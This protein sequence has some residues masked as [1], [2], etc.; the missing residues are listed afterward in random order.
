MNWEALICT[1]FLMDCVQLFALQCV[2]SRL[3]FTRL[4]SA[5]LLMLVCTLAATLFRPKAWMLAVATAAVYP[6]SVIILLGRQPLRRLA[7]ASACLFC[8]SAASA[9]FSSIGSGTLT[10]L[11]FPGVVLM[12]YLLR[13][14]WN[15]RCCWNIELFL[16]LDGL[17]ESFPAL[18]DTGNRLREGAS[19]LPVLIVESGAVPRVARHAAHMPPDRFKTLPYGVLGGG[20]RLR[21]FLPDRLEFEARGCPRRSAPECWVALYT[22]RIPGSTRALAPPE[23]LEF[24]RRSR[25]TIKRNPDMP[26]RFMY[27]IFKH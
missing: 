24:T 22:G 7:E 17:R 1:D 15:T 8:I 13:G 19:G 25:S 9:G 20:G 5:A 4:I 6:A 26:R 12:L 2:Y 11:V 3:R 21:C 18:I 23:F 27:G 10:L 16:E 14:R